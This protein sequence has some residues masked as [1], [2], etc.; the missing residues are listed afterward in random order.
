M[1]QVQVCILVI[2]SRLDKVIQL[3]DAYEQL[4]CLR[5]AC[6]IPGDAQKSSQALIKL[7]SELRSSIRQYVFSHA[8]VDI[9]AVHQ[10]ASPV[11]TITTDLAWFQVH[12]FCQ[13]VNKYSLCI[14]TILS[15]RE[16]S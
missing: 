1:D 7:S 2:H 15:L 12:L 6:Q 10:C 16:S 14:T 11:L 3:Y 5:M 4:C 13:V 8:L 9:R